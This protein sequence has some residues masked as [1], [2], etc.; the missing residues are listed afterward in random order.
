MGRNSEVRQF[1][2][3]LARIMPTAPQLFN[4]TNKSNTQD[5]HIA[6]MLA[7]TQQMFKWSGLPDTIPQRNL[8]L[9]LQ[10][11]GFTGIIE[12]EG[13]LYAMF[14]GLGGVPDEYYMPTQFI[15]ANPYLKLNKIYEIG[16]DVVIARSDSLYSG[17]MPMFGK[18]ADLITENEISFRMA[19]IN[20]RK[21]EI[22]T[23]DDDN[24]AAGVA[25]YYK[26]IEDGKPGVVVQKRFMEDNHVDVH[27][28]AQ[29]SQNIKDLIELNQYLKASWYNDLGIQANWNAKRE[30]LNTDEIELNIKALLPLVEDMLACRKAACEDVNK[31]FGTDWFVEF[32]SIWKDTVEEVEDMNQVTEEPEEAPAQSED[33]EQPEEEQEAEENV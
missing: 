27:P 18:Y 2:E 11:N 30:A 21:T 24:T 12:Y 20:A 15:V 4:V 1:R 9:L 28:A 13:N 14:G 17:L 19:T 16:K 8:E 3:Y 23:A 10:V 33:P 26:D 29:Q 25:K 6:Y 31:M 5:A 32:N 7:R 22:I